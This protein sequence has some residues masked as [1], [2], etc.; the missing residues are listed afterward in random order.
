MGQVYAFPATKEMHE[1]RERLK[2]KWRFKDLQGGRPQGHPAHIERGPK[3]RIILA[4]GQVWVEGH[5]QNLVVIRELWVAR[6]TF[7][8]HDVVF[9]PYLNKCEAHCLAETT[10]RMTHEIWDT[11]G[12]SQKHLMEKLERMSATDPQSPFRNFPDPG[13][14]AEAFFGLDRNGNR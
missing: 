11:W 13:A 5:T 9:A 4:V 7:Y 6:N 12:D 14:S 8:P 2:I 3:G 1:R 10:F